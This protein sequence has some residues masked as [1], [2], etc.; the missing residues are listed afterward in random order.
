M[1]CDDSQNENCQ[2]VAEERNGGCIETEAFWQER[3]QSRKEANDKNEPRASFAGMIFFDQPR[4]ERK[5]QNNG[6][7]EENEAHGVA[8]K[9]T[10]SDAS[11]EA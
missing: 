1:H 8:Q 5:I 9:D 3:P 2:I 6:W 4:V 11:K 7:E 10:K